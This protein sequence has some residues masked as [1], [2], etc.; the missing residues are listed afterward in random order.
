MVTVQPGGSLWIDTEETTARDFP[1]KMAEA[2]AGREDWKVVIKGDARLT[3]GEVQRTMF[4]IERAGFADVG[5]I[6][7][8]R[9]DS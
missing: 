8:R 4:A 1:Q 9:E 7:E 6:T 5:L 3:F 2:A